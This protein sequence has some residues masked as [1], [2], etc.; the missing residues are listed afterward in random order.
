MSM[1]NVTPNKK[2][3]ER[4]DRLES[5][6]KAY[7]K[8]STV[9]VFDEN[10]EGKRFF[11]LAKYQWNRSYYFIVSD[12]EGQIN[13]SKLIYDGW[14]QI[15]VINEQSRNY[16]DNKERFDAWIKSAKSEREKEIKEQYTFFSR[17]KAR[18]KAG[19]KSTSRNVTFHTNKGIVQLGTLMLQKEDNENYYL[20][21]RYKSTYIIA[22][23]IWC[24]GCVQ[25]RE[26]SLEEYKKD[27][28]KLID[29]LH[30]AVNNR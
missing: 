11:V 23:L 17:N 5:Y 12:V 20:V 9:Y 28:E 15:I 22:K 19:Q 25:A 7:K 3:V 26:L 1:N 21:I 10:L 2:K 16:I 8:G 13:V 27:E 14:P 6:Y 4:K 24:E 30:E 18:K 29:W